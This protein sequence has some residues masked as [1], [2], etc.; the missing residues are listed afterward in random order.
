VAT[1]D[2]PRQLVVAML[3][4][5]AA[6]LVVTLWWK[7]SV[8]S[9]AAGGTVAILALTFDPT[10][11]LAVPAVA[12]VTWSRVRLGDHTPPRPGWRRPRRAGRHHRLRCPAL[13]SSAEATTRNRAHE[14]AKHPQGSTPPSGQDEHPAL[15]RSQ[16][17]ILPPAETGRNATPEGHLS[18]ALEE[19]SMATPTTRLRRARALAVIAAALAALAV[20]LI[21]DPLLGI[22]LSAPTAPGSQ[23]LQ[24]ITPALVAGTSLVVAL[25]GWALLALLERFTA[26]ARTIWTA[27]ALLVALLSLAGPLSAL[28][29][30]TAANAVALALMHL[31]VAA[32]LIPGLVG[33]S[34]SPARPAPAREARAR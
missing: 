28:A 2:A 22:D 30:T 12:L 1:V 15:A 34:P 21:T 33:I 9:A 11:T 4:G 6:T 23:E 32:V 31:A 19:V 7:L 29:S 10:L 20:W 14:E 25:A 5:L 3:A 18:G 27:I 17:A 13:I 26:R 16:A 24:P 8:H